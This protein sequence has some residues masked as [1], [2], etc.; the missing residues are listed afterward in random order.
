LPK[1]DLPLSRLWCR[2]SALAVAAVATVTLAGCGGSSKPIGTAASPAT[3]V[4]ASAPLYIDAVVRPGD[5]LERQAL[6]VGRRLTQRARPFTGLL[7]LLQGPTGKTPGYEHEVKPWLGTHGGVFLSSA[8]AAGSGSGSGSGAIQE[9][10]QQTLGKILSEGLAGAESSLLGEGGL[11]RLL[12]GALQGAIVLDTIDVAKARSFLQAQAHAAGARGV[13]YRGVRYEVAP[14][15]IAEGVVHRFAVIGSEA[16]LKSVI[17]TAAGGPSLAHAAAYAKLAASAEPGRLAN[18]YVDTEALSGTVKPGG[19]AGSLL[20]LLGGLLGQSGPLYVSA[21]PGAASLTLDLD[22]LS[23]SKSSGGEAAAGA[24]VLRELPGNAWLAFGISDLGKTLGGGTQGLRALAKLVS[25]IRLGGLSA[26]KV[27]APLDSRS[28]DVRRDLL[29]WMGATGVYVGGSS[30]LNLQAAVV[31][32]SKDPARSRAAVAK[33]GRAYREAGGQT[34]PTSIPGTE[35]ALA[36][37]LPGFPLALTIADGQGKFVLGIGQSSI[38][39]ALRAQSMFASSSLYATAASALGHGLE[40][41]VAIEFRTLLGLIES[42][43]LTQTPGLS[44]IVSAVKPIGTLAAG[45]GEP[46][47]GGVTRARVVLGL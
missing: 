19:S 31:I 27:F 5:S 36:V 23:A 15:G 6:T 33:L 38:Q 30:I 43:G 42:L 35:A 2:S 24:K 10:L 41:S 21:I 8:G 12:H 13:S 37:K 32:S 25:S 26:T 9:L 17:D 20:A 47:P 11:R 22:T 45:S 7:A 14:D 34:T 16:G 28:I 46:L 18:A 44:G 3:V 40:P 29:S 39:E 1:P 4:P